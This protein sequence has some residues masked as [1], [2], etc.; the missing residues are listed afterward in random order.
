MKRLTGIFLAAAIA[1]SAAT[2]ASSA[3]FLDRF[4]DECKKGAL[5][6]AVAGGALGA[7]ISKDNKLRN[8]VLG[9]AAG[10]VAGCMI[11]KSLTQN[12]HDRLLAL[13]KKAAKSGTPKTRS[14]TNSTKNKVAATAF[15]GP[16]IEGCRQVKV[17]LSIDGGAAQNFDGDKFC[18]SSSGAWTQEQS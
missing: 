3:M 2:P 10:G 12:D 15:P 8:G 17:D 14:W 16:I 7:I 1:V 5:V 11:N 4:S 9:A 6:G 13:E 18:K